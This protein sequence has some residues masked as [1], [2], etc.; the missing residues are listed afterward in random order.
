VTYRHQLKLTHA[1]RTAVGVRGGVNE[2]SAYGG[3]QLLAVADGMGGHAHGELASA[4]AIQI[5]AA[6]DAGRPLSAGGATARVATAG[7]ATARV[8]TVSAGQ[9]PADRP[10]E[11]NAATC[12]PTPS[13]AV[14]SAVG[15]SVPDGTPPPP[16]PSSGDLWPAPNQPSLPHAP[17][18]G[19]GL[20]PV[21]ADQPP[22]APIPIGAPVI[23]L[24]EAVAEIGAR[25]TALVD[26]DEDRTGMGTTLTAFHW[27]GTGFAIAHVGDSRAY[28]LRDGRLRQLTHDHTLVQSLVDDGRITAEQAAEHPRR[29]VL[30]RALQAGATP[31]PDLFTWP[32]RAGD[33]YLLCSDGLTD[34]VPLAPIH[35]ILRTT[36]SPAETA[37]RLIA[38]AAQAGGHDNVTCLVVDVGRS[39]GFLGRLFRLNG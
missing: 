8:A 15:S 3:N 4:T 13:S 20:T 24:A 18:P 2:D 38:L 22:T 1:V 6:L 7:G 30:M 11:S 26:Q 19:E 28:L 12:P 36:S 14:S 33:R 16:I 34:Y 5:I 35:D 25:L 17:K 32:A 29:S 23:N 9:P 37:D 10:P 39:M 31:D 21:P 27:T